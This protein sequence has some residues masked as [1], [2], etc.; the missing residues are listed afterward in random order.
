MDT[1]ARDELIRGMIAEGHTLSDVQK[2][3]Q[4][5]HGVNITYMELRLLAAELQVNWDKVDGAKKAAEEKAKEDDAAETP[6]EGDAAPPG[7]TSIS[8]SPVVRPGSMFSGDVTFASG[9]TAEW[10]LDQFGR[11]G[12]ANES[13]K[14]DENDLMEFQQELQKALQ[15]RMG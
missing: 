8:V 5:E 10:Y 3:L 11:L 14:P 7:G 2:T 15:G 13:G 1:T 12:L 9:I 4:S 6:E